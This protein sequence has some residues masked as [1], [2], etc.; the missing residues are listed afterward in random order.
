[1]A[2]L[3]ASVPGTAP[4]RQAPTIC[5]R[6]FFLHNGKAGRPSSLDEHFSVAP[7]PGQGCAIG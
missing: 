7:D 2:A 1:M 3:I 4:F 5:G 6:G